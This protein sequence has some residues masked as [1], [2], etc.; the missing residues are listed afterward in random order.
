MLKIKKVK[1]SGFRGILNPQELSLIEEG[2]RPRSLVLY[3]LN[4]SGK[5]SI[6]D[7]LEWFLSSKDEIEWLNHDEA[8]Q[9]SY[10][11]LEA[12]NGESFVDIEFC[13]NEGKKV[14]T[15]VKTFNSEKVTQPTISSSEDFMSLYESFTI[16]PYLRYMEVIDFVYNKTGTEKYKKL[17]GWM[18]FEDELLFQQKISIDIIPFIKD[19]EKQILNS[20][21]IL[22][23]GLVRFIGNTTLDESV[24]L[25]FCNNILNKY[26]FLSCNSIEN[27]IEKLPEINKLKISYSAGSKINKISEI[28]NF[29][30]S[31]GLISDNFI[32]E[33]E[34]LK[35]EINEFRK[36]LKLSEKIDIINL[37]TQALDILNKMSSN[38]I[39]C[40]VC[41]IGWDRKELSEY[42]KQKFLVL[43]K[44]KNDREEILTKINKLKG[45]LE[46][47]QL[48][49]GRF[50]LKYDELNSVMSIGYE[51]TKKYQKNLVAFKLAINQDLFNCDIDIG[52]KKEEIA[53]INGEKEIIKKSIIIEKSKI[54]LPQE[55]IQRNEDIEKINKTVEC[56]QEIVDIDKK[57]EFYQKEF[58]RVIELSNII[59]KEIQENIKKRF[60]DISDCISRYFKILRSD[61][62]IKDI[63][64]I[65]NEER[66]RA[67]GRSAEIRLDYYDISV[68]PAYKVL[69][70]SLLNSLG[71]AVYFTCVKKFNNKCGFIVLD[72]IMNSL[73][74]EKR[75]TVLDLLSQEFS[76]FQMIILTHDY[77]WFQKIMQRF[78]TWIAKKIKGWDYKLGSRI[79]IVKTTPEEI[80]ILLEDSTTINRAGSTLCLYIEGALN[81]LCENLSAEVRYRYIKNDPPSMDELF[82]A[83]YKRLK[84]KTNIKHPILDKISDT[85]NC[86]PLLR[87]FTNHPR[88]NYSSTIS[89]TEVRFAMEKWF[90][91]E[92][93][94]FCSICN[95]YIEYIKEK[96]SIE[97]RCGELKVDKSSV[98]MK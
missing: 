91:L 38:K 9:K 15:L 11:H 33:I 98:K 57:I 22:E 20:R 35:K 68:K 1:L 77:F 76:D 27:L 8:K 31:T 55:D 86:E 69:S 32:K 45:K 84:D 40:P 50:I 5:T 83:L 16:K 80:N 7:A 48:T 17:A 85:K 37:Y 36:D 13:D 52:T 29:L 21:K 89:S 67:I 12:K 4:S 94:L 47:E 92:K 87:N 44:V 54:Q 34:L 88:E 79:D 23:D 10:P 24:I 63:E 41:G 49:V 64:I 93:D 43:Q 61:K 82:I 58:K 65:L 46:G 74:I 95:R 62:D 96:D 26:K 53:K 56:W 72:D 73:D 6:V 51:E 14:F 25:D 2:D 78:P 18:G 97:C 81:K 66:G 70:E 75:D 30:N 39:D 3:G 19:E 71:L 42:I 90:L 59:V 28:E 60:G